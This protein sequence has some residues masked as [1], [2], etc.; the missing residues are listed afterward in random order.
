M[1]RHQEIN[2]LR[3]ENQFLSQVVGGR[4]IEGVISGLRD[5]NDHL[6]QDN[7][8]LNQD[9][10]RLYQDLEI[11]ASVRDNR[12]ATQDVQI[13]NLQE[14]VEQYSAE[15]RERGIRTIPMFARQD[16][17]FFNNDDMDTN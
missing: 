12:I 16:A 2:R 13:R 7:D 4:I 3:N 5:D 17:F 6:N 11:V 10:Q 1:L 15:L 14:R 8:Y 9:N